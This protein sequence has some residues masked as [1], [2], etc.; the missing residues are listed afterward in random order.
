MIIIKIFSDY[1]E[2]E[3]I[4][5][6]YI[7]TQHLLNDPNYN[8]KYTLTCN[9]DYTHA[10][11]LNKAMPNLKNEIPKENVIGLAHEPPEF[12]G[13][14]YKNNEIF[15]D[16]NY[17]VDMNFINFVKNKVGKYY[18]G[19]KYNLPDEFIEGFGYLGHCNVSTIYKQP[20]IK[21]KIMSLMISDKLWTFGHNY[22]HKIAQIIINNNLPIDIYG[23]GCSF[24]ET[25][26]ERLKGSFNN[27][28]HIEN[29]LFTIAIENTS[30]PHYFSEKIINPLLYKTNVIYYGC[31]NI[32]DYFPKNET[33]MS[34]GYGIYLLNG[35][36]NHDMNIIINI[37][38]NWQNHYTKINPNKIFNVVN[39]KNIFIQF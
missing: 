2:S 7:L 36:I 27:Q 35:D 15:K 13:L 33:T 25:N 6:N 11:I 10:I 21:N 8:N 1:C 30:H 37:L 5:N 3:D 38:N 24:Y 14:V 18:I 20:I 31:K 26:N 28:E 32:C 19:E 17:L 23:R 16:D 39:I 9:D 12:L 4:I 22:R 34:D 29:Y